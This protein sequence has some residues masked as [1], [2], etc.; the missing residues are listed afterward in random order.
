M[1][2]IIGRRCLDLGD[3]CSC[4]F[5]KFLHEKAKKLTAIGS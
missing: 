5:E 2:W 4:L 3:E 1:K